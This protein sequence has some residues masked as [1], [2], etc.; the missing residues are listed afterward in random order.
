MVRINK[1]QK[2]VKE[3]GNEWTKFKNE[4]VELESTLKKQFDAYSS[5]L[6]HF[7]LPRN[8]IA[9]DFGAGSGR[10]DKYF[11]TGPIPSDDFLQIRGEQLQGKR[12]SFD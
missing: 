9:A 8:M 10:W 11:E 2:V 12:E 3:F 6:A 1:N 5:P 7:D 4:K